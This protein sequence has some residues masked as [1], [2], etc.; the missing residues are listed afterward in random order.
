MYNEKWELFMRTIK[1]VCQGLIDIY[2]DEYKLYAEAGRAHEL[3]WDKFIDKFLIV[4]IADGYNE[5]N[6]K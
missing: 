2:N 4:L 6:S 3:T 5:M 1:G